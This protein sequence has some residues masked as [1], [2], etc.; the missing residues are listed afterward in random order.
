MAKKQATNTE[1]AII[2][3]DIQYIKQEIEEIKKRLDGQFVTRLEFESRC[4]AIDDKFSPGLKI[5][6][7][8][9]TLVLTGV[10]GALL[11]LVINSNK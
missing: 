7:G 2:A 6:Y 11:A 9:V 3:T 4:K 8:I 10:C 1:V 5:I